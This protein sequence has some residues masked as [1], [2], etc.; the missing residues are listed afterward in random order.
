MKDSMTPAAKLYNWSIITK[1]LEVYGVHIEEEVKS[2]I[3]AGD[4]QLIVE[5]LTQIKQKENDFSSPSA[6]QSKP[7]SDNLQPTGNRAKNSKSND[8]ARIFS[9]FM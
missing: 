6:K 4:L 3:V 2:L 8:K 5:L 1:A 7:K 9:Y